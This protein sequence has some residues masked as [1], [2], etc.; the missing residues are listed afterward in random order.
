MYL[1]ILLND[2][3]TQVM[4]KLECEKIYNYIHNT[5]NEKNVF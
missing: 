3:T 5:I 1:Q 2:M 4:H